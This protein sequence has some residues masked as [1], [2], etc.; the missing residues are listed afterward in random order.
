MEN[1]PPPLSF[2][3]RAMSNLER[4]RQ[5]QIHEN[6][7]EDSRSEFVHL[8]RIAEQLDRGYKTRK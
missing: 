4:G 3:S 5:S 1:A 7:L 8:R 6:W 2:K